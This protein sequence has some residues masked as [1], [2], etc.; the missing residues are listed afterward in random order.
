MSQLP[1]C[2]KKQHEFSFRNFVFE[3]RRQLVDF[4]KCTG[5]QAS[6][7]LFQLFALPLESAKL[8]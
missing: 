1:R 4:H 6:F 2:L 3:A 8:D 5:T 7:L